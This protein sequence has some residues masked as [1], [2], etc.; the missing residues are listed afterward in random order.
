V[1]YCD[2]SNWMLESLSLA[3]PEMKRART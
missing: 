3:N 2:A 1:L